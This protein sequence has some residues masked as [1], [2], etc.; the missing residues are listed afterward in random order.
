MGEWRVLC[1][2]TE[3]R[4]SG[5][6][7]ASTSDDASGT[8]DAPVGY[9]VR[10][11]LYVASFTSWSA[12]DFLTCAVLVP[13][14]IPIRYDKCLILSPSNVHPHAHTRWPSDMNT[15]CQDYSTASWRYL[16]S[17]RKLRRA[18]EISL[19]LEPHS[20]FVVPRTKIPSFQELQT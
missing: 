17:M 6:S 8:F 7:D 15:C 9:E 19:T 18:L 20:L 13:S 12:V 4:S 1:R 16:P 10:G 14:V 3:G 2:A 11:C 5:R